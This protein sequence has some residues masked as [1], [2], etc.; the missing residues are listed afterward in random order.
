MLAIWTAS[1]MLLQTWSQTH[2][3][4]KAVA[5]HCV[6]STCAGCVAMQCGHQ[7]HDSCF[8]TEVR[9]Q[10]SAYLGSV[11]SSRSSTVPDFLSHCL[12]EWRGSSYCI[13]LTST[14]QS[15]SL[16]TIR[17]PGDA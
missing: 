1:A 12:Q 4:R 6:Q 5:V 11:T 9:E 17:I 14:L 7:K 16:Q 8:N 2:S 13:L 10:G 3:L 15:H